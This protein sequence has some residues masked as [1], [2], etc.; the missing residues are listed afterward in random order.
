[1]DQRRQRL[2]EELAEAELQ[3][4]TAAYNDKVYVGAV[5]ATNWTKAV[6]GSVGPFYYADVEVAIPG[7]V[8]IDTGS[9]ATMSLSCSK[10]R[11]RQLIYPLILSFQ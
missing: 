1:M 8:L 7:R 10:A 6:A 4:M 11:V 3:R 2:R 5:T 9:P